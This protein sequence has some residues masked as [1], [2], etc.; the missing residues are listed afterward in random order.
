MTERGTLTECYL[1]TLS[2]CSLLVK[3]CLQDQT[4]FFNDLKPSDLFINS[5]VVCCRTH[6]R[7]W[8]GTPFSLVFWFSLTVVPDYLSWGKATCDGIWTLKSVNSATNPGLK[9]RVSKPVQH[10][11]MTF[12]NSCGGNRRPY[13]NT[14]GYSTISSTTL[15]LRT[16]PKDA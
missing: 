12:L 5:G 14:K 10:T 9:M 15:I 13:L 8:R 7:M 1:S 16:S 2:D 6:K 11:D 4:L 3:A